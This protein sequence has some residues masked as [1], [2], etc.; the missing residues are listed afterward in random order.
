MATLSFEPLISLSVWLTLALAGAMLL[1][2]YGWRRPGGV[3]PRRWIGILT[4]MSLGLGLVLLFPRVLRMQR[5]GHHDQTLSKVGV[6]APVSHFVCIRQRTAGDA[7][8]FGAV[9]VVGRRGREDR[10]LRLVL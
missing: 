10:S 2:W 1:G 8:V 5:A 3:T 6:D 7:A 4:Q 9:E